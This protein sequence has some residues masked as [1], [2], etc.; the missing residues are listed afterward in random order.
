MP[1]YPQ[2]A[3]IAR[4]MCNKTE[5]MSWLSDADLLPFFNTLVYSRVQEEIRKKVDWEYFSYEF[6][7][8]IV[9]G[10]DKY[11]LPQSD[12]TAP[13]VLKIM[14]LAIKDETTD[15]YYEVLKQ[16]GVKWKER[17]TDYEA[18]NAN[19]MY[20]DKRGG[21]VYLYPTPADDITNWIKILASVTLP[22][23]DSTATEDEIFPNHQ[24]LRVYHNVLVIWLKAVVYAIAGDT[25]MKQEAE[26]EFERA[27]LNMVRAMQRDQEPIIA[28][29]VDLSSFL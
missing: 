28:E 26:A 8:N 5:S 13:W 7:T 24:Q 15:D 23:I 29:E 18:V 27:L 3:S 25:A 22:D 14:K 21:Y 9:G 12:S 17:Y 10:Q 1:S 2:I 20:Y 4:V 19:P 6:T 11:Q 16:E